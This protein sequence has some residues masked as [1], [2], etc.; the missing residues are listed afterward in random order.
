MQYS[1]IVCGNLYISKRPPRISPACS[2]ACMMVRWKT[3]NRDKYLA[4]RAASRAKIVAARGPREAVRAECNHCGQQYE[5]T[6]SW[7]K[8]CSHKCYGASYRLRNKDRLREQ[9][10]RKLARR[11]DY[12]NAKAKYY[13]D[14]K[15][16]SGNRMS[17]L[18]RDGF[19][20]QNCGY[21]SPDEIVYKG[22]ELVMHHKD[23]SGSSKQPNNRIE[24]LQTLCRACH[25]RI[26]THKVR[27]NLMQE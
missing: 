12:Y 20:C 26:H 4:S 19:T 14:Q 25:I 27:K 13:H 18:E 3:L 22:Q 7:Q 10:H 15:H 21:V 2:N 6:Y 9:H 24:N 5:K 8:F 11:K 1:C 16:F 17:A 23:F